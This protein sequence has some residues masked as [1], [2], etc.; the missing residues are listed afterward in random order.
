MLYLESSLRLQ[1]REQ[2]RGGEDDEACR[3]EGVTAVAR[4]KWEWPE[5]RG[6]P[7]GWISKLCSAL[8][9][10]VEREDGGEGS[11]KT[12]YGFQQLSK[13]CCLLLGWE[14]QEKGLE[15]TTNYRVGLKWGQE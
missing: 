6:G 11:R 4:L 8:G 2:S 10:A 14:I 15:F 5:L 3:L 9:W 1:G 7:G 12:G 13:L